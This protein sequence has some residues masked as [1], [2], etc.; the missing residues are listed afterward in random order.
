MF[1]ILRGYVNKKNYIPSSARKLS[2]SD[3][4]N[5]DIFQYAEFYHKLIT[6]LNKYYP[7]QVKVCFVTYDTT[8]DEYLKRIEKEFNPFHISLTSETKSNQFSTVCNA[9]HNNVFTTSNEDEFFLILRSDI[10][11]TD[12]LIDKICTYPFHQKKNLLYTICQDREIDWSREYKSVTPVTNHVDILHGFY[13][14]ILPE[15][16]KW[17]CVGHVHAHQIHHKFGVQ[18]MYDIEK[19]KWLDT[20]QAMI[21][22]MERGMIK[23]LYST[24]S[25]YDTTYFIHDKYIDYKKRKES[26]K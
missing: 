25:G 9:L 23:P 15:V 17:M 16:R 7:R 4:Y 18:P 10:L 3:S 8:G 11:M 20:K 2:V 13:S 1:L 12:N 21:D 6:E 5:I 14:L 24:W 22:Y 19:T 26:K